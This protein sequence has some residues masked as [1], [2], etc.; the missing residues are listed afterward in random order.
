MTK[1]R[2]PRETQLHTDT[3]SDEAYSYYGHGSQSTKEAFTEYSRAVNEVNIS[4]TYGTHL[5]NFS[6]L[7][8][9]VSSYPGFTRGDYEAYRPNQAIPTKHKD[10]MLLSTHIYENQGLVKNVIDLMGDFA[11]QGIRITHP[12]PGKEKFFQSWFK[13]VGG[14]DRSERFLNYLYR[15]ANVIVKWQTGRLSPNI[16]K[17]MFKAKANDNVIFQNTTLKK[18]ELPLKY[19]FLNPAFI[20]VVGGELAAFVG[21]PQYAIILS[22]NLR[23][24]IKR[25]DNTKEI[26]ELLKQLPDDIINAAKSRQAFPLDP[27]RTDT[28]FYKKDDWS[29]W[30][31]PIIYSIMKDIFLLD[32]LKLADASALDGAISSIRIFKLGNLEHK[33][34]PKKIAMVKFAQMLEAN[35]GAGPRNLVWGPDVEVIENKTNVHEFLGKE[36]YDPTLNAIYQ[37]LGVPPTLTG[38][39]G[40]AGTTNNFISLKTLTQRL[41][42]GRNVLISLWDKQ[43]SLVQKSMDFRLPA[44]IDFDLTNLAD[45]EAQKALLVQLA[46]RNIISHEV[47]QHRF[48]FNT[49]M[50]KIRLNREQRDRE[51]NRQVPQAGPYH[52]SQPGFQLKKTAL[53]TGVLTPSQVGIREEEKRKDF[54]MYPKKRGEKLALEFKATLPSRP[55]N[56]KPKKSGGRPKTSKDSPGTRVREKKFTPQSRGLLEVW[57][58]NAQQRIASLLNPF[59]LQ[60]ISKKNLRALTIGQAQELESLKFDVLCNHAPLVNIDIHTINDA[61]IYGSVEEISVAYDEQLKYIQDTMA[62]KISFDEKRKLQASVYANFYILDSSDS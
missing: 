48:G 5:H 15:Q 4:S 32:Q 57:S 51:E 1:K 31:K 49:S 40:A 54:K 26:S 6:N 42:Y 29:L 37:G 24:L 10:I 11:C 9:N 8:P 34:I 43:L 3:Y 30:A 55:S 18:G 53:Q 22:E 59:Y 19:T 28:Y 41:E 17:D 7:I 58:A 39:F 61:L 14:K 33:I 23:R 21:S 27:N 20:E 12:N 52:D 46:D 36:K 2:P 47:L 13:K 60:S 45:E 62:I 56:T 50:E 16:R 35:T 44:I 38:T 25:K